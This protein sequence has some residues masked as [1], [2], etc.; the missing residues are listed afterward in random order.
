MT[1]YEANYNNCLKLVKRLA[2]AATGK[3]SIGFKYSL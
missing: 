3:A 1:R 2:V